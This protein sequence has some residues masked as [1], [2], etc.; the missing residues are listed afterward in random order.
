MLTRRSFLAVSSA[1]IA[2][3]A[4][5]PMTLAR[6]LLTGARGGGSFTP[7]PPA[8]MPNQGQGLPGSFTKYA[9]NPVLA[10]GGVGAWDSEG[11]YGECVF[12]DVRLGKFVM[13]YSST[14]GVEAGPYFQTGLAY[15]DDLLTWTK[16]ATNPVFDS[17][18]PG[19]VAP[20]IVQLA[21]Q[22]YV[23]YYQSWPGTSQV[24]CA[25]SDDLLS[26]TIQNGGNPVLPVRS[27]QWDETYTFDPCARLMDDGTTIQL[28]YAGMDH[29]WSR[30][31][32]YA[33]TTDGVTMTDRS[34]LAYWNFATEIAN[35]WGTPSVVASSDAAWGVFV[36]ASAVDGYRFIDRLWTTDNGAGSTPGGG[37]TLHREEQVL[38]KSGSGWDSGQVFDAAAIWWQGTLYLIYCGTTV[39]GGAAELASSIG[40]ATMSWPAV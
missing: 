7:P 17:G 8:G 32:G 22:S 24:Y 13:A 28:F 35:N 9:G 12:R 30:A 23:M 36:D 14:D 37:T 18:A 20:T 29:F 39:V 6:R 2:L 33:L 40:A 27:G 4:C 11:L 1:A 25:T 10:P 16:E 34:F 21:D 31:I 5:D 15:S 38:V 3:A 26:W 19:H